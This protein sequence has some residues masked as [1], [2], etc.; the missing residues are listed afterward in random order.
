MI[1][2]KERLCLSPPRHH[3]KKQEKSALDPELKAVEP[4]NHNTTRFIFELPDGVSPITSLVVTG[5]AIWPCARILSNPEQEG[6]LVLLIKKYENGVISNYVHERL[7]PGD[8]LAIKG[9]ISKFPYKAN[10]FGHVALIGGGSG[11]TPLYQLLNHALNDPANR[12]FSSAR[13]LPCSTART[14][15]RPASCTHSTTPPPAGWSGASGY[16]SKELIRA[17]VPPAERGDKVQV[18]ICG[19][20]GQVSAVAGEKDG[21]KQGAIGGILKELGYT[22]VQNATLNTPGHRFDIPTKGDE[23]LTDGQYD[24]P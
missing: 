21:P 5:R 23:L 17:H 24:A 13:S 12:T 16:V 7:K 15:T 22:E 6:E 19:P 14:R 8:A 11:V 10:G 20:P 4:Y 3:H 18:L 2:P 9:P 1:I